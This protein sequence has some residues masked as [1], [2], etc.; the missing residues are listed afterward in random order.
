MTLPIGC[1]HSEHSIRIGSQVPVV[2]STGV[3]QPEVMRILLILSFAFLGAVAAPSRT[4]DPADMLSGWL[5]GI[6]PDELTGS[7]PDQ[8]IR[9][10]EEA[11]LGRLERSAAARPEPA[12]CRQQCFQE[13]GAFEAICDRHIK[14]DASRSRAICYLRVEDERANCISACD[15]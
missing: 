9:D 15:Q 2:L 4:N 6:P 8:S 10:I 7:E 11:L 13:S 12:S 1:D 14:P 5:Q 3:E